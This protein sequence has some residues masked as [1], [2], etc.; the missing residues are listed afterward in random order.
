MKYRFQDGIV[1]T[2]IAKVHLLVATRKAWDRYPA[3]K[4]VN[5]LQGTFCEG[6]SRGM[7]E[8]EIVQAIL[9]P[10]RMSRDSVRKRLSM[11]I[12][13]M[14]DERYIVPEEE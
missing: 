14:L 8:E 6:I 1:Y 9:L 12:H 10:E 3:I 13:K 7:E 11:F 4:E 5:A 2:K